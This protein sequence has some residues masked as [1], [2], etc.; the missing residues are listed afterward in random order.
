VRGSGPLLEVSAKTGAGVEDWIGWL[1]ANLAAQ[2]EAIA[3]SPEP[4]AE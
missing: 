4:A 1:K 3:L 2:R